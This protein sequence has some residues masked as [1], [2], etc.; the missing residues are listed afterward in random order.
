M[1][2]IMQHIQWT[3]QFRVSKEINVGCLFKMNVWGNRTVYAVQQIVP[4]YFNTIHEI[5]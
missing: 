2:A 1:M 5:F 4:F 3:R